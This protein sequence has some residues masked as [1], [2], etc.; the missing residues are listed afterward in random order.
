MDLVNKLELFLEVV[1][2]G[3]FSRAAEAKFMDKSVFSKQIKLLENELGVRL[4]NRTTRSVSLTHVGEEFVSRAE[5]IS[6]LLH[7]TKVLAKSYQ[8]EPQGTIKILAPEFFARN[9]LQDI[10]YNFMEK[11]P[12]VKVQ[13]T[14][15][16][17]P[18]DIISDG[19]DFAIKVG[20]LDNNRLI[21]KRLCGHHVSLLASET[22]IEKYG[23]PKTPDDLI[24]FPAAVFTNGV[25]STDFVY[26]DDEYGKRK[27]YNLTP[28]ITVNNGRMALDAIRKGIGLGVVASFAPNSEPESKFV[29]LLPKFKLS[30]L[31][32]VGLYLL[33]PHRNQPAFVKLMIAEI[34][35]GMEETEYWH[36]KYFDVNKDV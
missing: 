28:K 22:F 21:A 9:Y 6:D 19:F 7:D 8:D 30:Q 29:K 33:Y 17:R 32:E 2:K 26:F 31:D 12:K 25:F 36:N 3:S 13:L 4:F 23:E 10:I 1:N 18:R 11:H 34:S 20:E 15:D 14:L 35:A 16:N 5:Q 27:R 24:N